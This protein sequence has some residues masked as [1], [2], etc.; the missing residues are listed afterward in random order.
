MMAGQGGRTVL[1]ASY[2]ILIARA[3]GAGDF[4]AF[5]ATVALVG[6]LVPFSGFGAS[7][8]MIQKVSVDRSLAPLFWANAVRVTFI[9]GGVLSV[10]VVLL[11]GWLAPKGVGLS[12]V[13]CIALADLMFTP[14]SEAAG[15]A[16]IAYER[17][18]R[19]A[20]FYIWQSGIR[21]AG[22][23]LLVVGPWQATAQTWAAVYFATAVP[24]ACVMWG[25]A[26]RHIGRSKPDLR[27]FWRERYT[28]FFFAISLAA[29]SVYND[30]DKA[31]LGRLASTGAAGIYSAAYRLIDVS[32]TPV[33][34]L[35]AAS[36][37]RFFQH[38]EEGLH[39]TVQFA[40]R[41]APPALGYAAAA[42]FALFAGAALVPIILGDSYDASVGALRGLSVLPLLKASHY[43]AANSLTGAGFQPVR[44]S[45]QVA[46]AI[47]NVLLNLWLIP[48]YSWGG[49]VAASIA[50]DGLLV[51]LLW[52]IVCV[53]LRQDRRPADRGAT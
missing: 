33:R 49:A 43:L 3:L 8:I 17:L 46:V 32:F 51:V 47:A 19:T 24:S 1:Q 10:A 48:N 28:G 22:A 15:T 16:F 27:M 44:T 37:P 21:L 20:S 25:I 11:S 7:Q 34:S 35:L 4:G 31:M 40:R 29:T 12:T 36:Y 14:I 45:A 18:T 23:I 30:T 52:S 41:I 39:A 13:A 6:I 2:F 38:G 50:S 26:T 42:S 9:S 53:K 5:A